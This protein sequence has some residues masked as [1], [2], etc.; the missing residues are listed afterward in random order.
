MTDWI[1]KVSGQNRH[2]NWNEENRVKSILDQ[3]STVVF[4]YDDSGERAVK[5]GQ[6]GESVYV[7]RFYSLKNGGLGSKHIFAG[8]TRVVTKLEK[9]GGSL[10][11]GIPGSIAFTNSNGIDNGLARGN[12]TK[13]GI[14]R[15]LP[16]PDGTYNTTNPPLEKFEFFYHGDHLGSSSFI[17]DD[18][19]AVYQHLEYFPY[20]ETWVEE[21]GTGQM[22]MYR[23]TG[24][25]LDPETGLY[26]YGARYYDPVLSRWISA[27][28]IL[29]KYLPTGDKKRDANLPGHGG[30]YYTININMYHY[31]ANNPIKYIDPN[32]EELDLVGTS[33]EIKKLAGIIEKA[34]GTKLQYSM[35]KTGGKG[36]DATYKATVSGFKSTDDRFNTKPGEGKSIQ[37]ALK[38]II[39]SDKNVTARF[40]VK[41][42]DA[43]LMHGGG[44]FDPKTGVASLNMAYSKNDQPE[45][46]YGRQAASGLFDLGEPAYMT[47]WDTMAHELIGHGNDYATG[48]PGAREGN[49]QNRQNEVRA[50]MGLPIIKRF[51]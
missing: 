47:S 14:N 24:K 35:E 11:T 3:G 38:D 27:D 39:S 26:Y 20:G 43:T 37:G 46:F 21:G 8:E 40:D 5:R 15:R 45:V 19:G 49:A 22:S 33:Q 50:L 16:N 18:A 9:D 23:F 32:G 10:S 34:T 48:I 31:G 30:V 28:P 51:P 6:M 29:G 44:S 25:E 13:K 2:L 17:T 12:G 41:G 1:S 36:K 4:L 7:N 42:E